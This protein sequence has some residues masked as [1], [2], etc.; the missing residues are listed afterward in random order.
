MLI[1][2]KSKA[3][4]GIDVL[5]TCDVPLVEVGEKDARQ[6]ALHCEIDP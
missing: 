1:F 4:R 6:S 5:P 2:E 3:G